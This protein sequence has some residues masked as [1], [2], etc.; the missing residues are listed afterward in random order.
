MEE[1]RRIVEWTA[2]CQKRLVSSSLSAE[3]PQP[4]L[5]LDTVQLAKFPISF[6]PNAA[7]SNGGS[8]SIG[9]RE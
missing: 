1:A 7:A 9:T 4:G 5:L 3:T 6:N 8:I 2:Y